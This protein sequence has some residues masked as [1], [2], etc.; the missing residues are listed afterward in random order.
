MI[1]KIKDK[2]VKLE[3]GIKAIDKKIEDLSRQRLATLGAIGVLNS[4][5]KDEEKEAAPIDNPK[6]E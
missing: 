6:A 4:L 2:K 5:I 1:D 3:E